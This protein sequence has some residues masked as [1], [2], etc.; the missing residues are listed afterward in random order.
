MAKYFLF[1]FLKSGSFPFSYYESPPECMSGIQHG[2]P[3]THSLL[4]HLST[5]CHRV[6]TGAS[7]LCT[8]VKPWT[9]Q[10]RNPLLWGSES[11]RMST[12]DGQVDICFGIRKALVWRTQQG[13]GQEMAVGIS[14]YQALRE[15]LF[16]ERTF[17]QKCEWREGGNEW[18]H[19]LGG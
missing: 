11:R 18:S 16:E 7:T 14:L 10:T 15:D 1:K 19:V 17:E 6:P 9:R 12:T 3:W 2:P 13:E 8:G 4:I 5:H